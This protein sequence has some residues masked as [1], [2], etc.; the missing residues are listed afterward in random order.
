MIGHFV[1]GVVR[2]PHVLCARLQSSQC[3]IRQELR[4]IYRILG[5]FHGRKFGDCTVTLVSEQQM[6][7]AKFTDEQYATINQST[8]GRFDLRVFVNCLQLLTCKQLTKT[9]RSKRPVVD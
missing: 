2:T 5:N 6:G 7:V 4:F 3:T 8:T 1:N 9:L